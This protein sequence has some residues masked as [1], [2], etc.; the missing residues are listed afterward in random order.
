MCGKEVAGRKMRE[1]V[2]SG[3]GRNGG[4]ISLLSVAF[5]AF[6]RL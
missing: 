1:G 4:S 5:F 3:G 2:K 6:L